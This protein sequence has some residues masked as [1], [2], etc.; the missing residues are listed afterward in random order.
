MSSIRKNPFLILEAGV[1][2]DGSL[3]KALSLVDS[4]RRSGAQAVKFQTYT[5]EKLAADLSPSY[6]NLKEES[7]NSQIE[8]FRK[9][10][11]LTYMDYKVLF[12]RSE[13]IGIEFMTTCFDE[14]WVDVMDPL[15]KRY[16]IASA[17]ITN[18]PLIR[19]IAKKR[20]PIILSTGASSFSEIQS[21]I[22][23]IREINQ[24]DLCIMHCVLNYPTEIENA[25]LAR[26]QLL[27]DSF[28]SVEIGYSDHTRPE[29]STR[30][31][32]AAVILGANIIETHFTLDNSQSGN[33]HYHSM[34]EMEV[35]NLLAELRLT[36]SMV[37]YDDQDFLE[38]QSSARM[39]A[40]RGIYLRN[41]LAPGTVIKVEDLEMLRP[42]QSDGIPSS[43]VDRVVGLKVTKPKLKRSYLAENDLE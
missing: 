19:H 24:Q 42:I 41:N 38:I 1:N 32:T 33:D 20:K 43:E 4:A 37:E 36:R 6:W 23:E 29:F 10:D 39:N 12:D 11:K 35:I 30:A 8:L 15:L 26:I 40:R 25:N 21:A 2:H 27:S 3:E 34:E 13:A 18:L 9:Y 28:P 7:T 16:K 22:G 14:E 31:I 5:A 17:D